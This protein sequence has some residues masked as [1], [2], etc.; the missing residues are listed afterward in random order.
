MMFD[1]LPVA[2]PA[3]STFWTR[4]CHACIAVAPTHMASAMM[5]AWTKMVF[6]AY[7]MDGARCSIADEPTS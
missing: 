2:T 3:L 7:R 5:P 1:M 6:G 4:V